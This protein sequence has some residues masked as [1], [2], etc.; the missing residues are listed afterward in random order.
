MRKFY[1]FVVLLASTCLN[2]NAQHWAPDKDNRFVTVTGSAE[3]NVAPDQI[4]LEIVLKEY[5][6]EDQSKRPIVIKNKTEMGKIETRFFEV[7]EKNNIAKSK[8]TYSDNSYYWYY[9]WSSRHAGLMQKRYSLT[10]DSDTDFLA[11]MQDL[12]FEG[13]QSIRISNSTNA[14]LQDMRKE[15]KI[16]AVKA[17]KEKASYLLES[18]GE[19]VGSV[20]QIMEVNNDSQYRWR[21]NQSML[22]NVA[23]NVQPSEGDLS[24]IARIELRYE[25]TA[26]FEIK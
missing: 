26:S 25:I 2:S 3:M 18:I 14:K 21:T 5:G 15:V 4:T 22:S 17:A 1:L 8:V 11:L 6:D 24:N 9:W 16:Q 23:I 12:D 13:V 19:Q 7:I 20:I 10:L